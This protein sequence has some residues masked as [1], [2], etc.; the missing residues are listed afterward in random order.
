MSKIV[1]TT[2][3]AVAGI[4]FAGTA[5]ALPLKPIGPAGQDSLIQPI[6]FQDGSSGL[7]DPKAAPQSRSRRSAIQKK[8]VSFEGNEGAGTII[9]DTGERR[10]YY[11]LENGKAIQYGIGVGRP[12]FQWSGV[13]RVTRKAEWPGWTPPPA[14]RSRQPNLPHYMPGGPN[15]PLG[16]RAL[17][18][19][20]T[21]YRI[22]GSNEPWTIGHAVSSGC[23][24]MT[25]EDVR[26]LY[27]KVGVGT[28]V[29]V[30]RGN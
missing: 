11:V 18:I 28:K 13:H 27:E 12:G 24:R 15:N 25:N 23:I 4:F 7:A 5:M 9:V 1:K 21:I 3:L 30:R 2:G 19:G 8:V 29:V 14:M 22:H 10:L 6:M 17:Y 26:D 20:S 16:A